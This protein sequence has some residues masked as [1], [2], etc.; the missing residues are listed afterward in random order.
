MLLALALALLAILVA[1]R[2]FRWLPIPVGGETRANS[3]GV[4]SGAQPWWWWALIGV[5]AAS[6]LWIAAIQLIPVDVQA[7]ASLPGRKAYLDALTAA[8][9][10]VPQSLPLSLNPQATWTA[11]W[12]ALPVSAMLLAGITLDRT[13]IDRLLLLLFAGAIAQVVLAVLQFVGGPQSIFY[14]GTQGA[15]GAFVGTFANRNHLADFLAMLIP[16]W[17]YFLVRRP[18]PSRSRPDTGLLPAAVFRPLWMLLGFAFLVIIL[19]SQS[20]GGLSAA[21]LVLVLSFFLYVAAAREKLSRVQIAGMATLLVV[22][23]LIVAFSVGLEGIS[24]RVQAPVLEGDANVRNTYAW[25]TFDAAKAFWPWGTGIGSFESVFP[26]YQDIRSTGY[27]YHAHNDYP[28]LLMELGWAAPVVAG[29]V[30]ALVLRQLWQLRRARKRRGEV[31]GPVLLRLLAGL[32][33]LAML[34]H[35]WVEFNMHIPAL[36]MTAALLMGIFLRP[37]DPHER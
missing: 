26:R 30:L 1:Q 14:F 9:A 4:R 3:T 17:F 18:P 37:T 8:G 36:A 23:G 10:P 34:L 35:S 21:T 2:S 12:S 15:G 6:P 13:A 27:V 11:M 31:A 29:L 33:V 25:A 22:F 20:R 32:G 16:L 5:V 28:Q 7:W 24:G 19:S